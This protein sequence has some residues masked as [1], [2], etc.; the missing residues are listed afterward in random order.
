MDIFT[1]EYLIRNPALIG[2]PITCLAVLFAFKSWQINKTKLALDE[3]NLMNDF[4]SGVAAL[5]EIQEKIKRLTI[6][7][8]RE[9]SEEKKQ[10]DIELL[11]SIK[12]EIRTKEDKLR[13]LHIPLASVYN[14]VDFID[15]HISELSE[16]NEGKL[17]E[18]EEFYK[19]KR[20]L[21]AIYLSVALL[22]PSYI[23]RTVPDDYIKEKLYNDFF[24]EKWKAL[25]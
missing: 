2:V 4:Y 3:L 16:A 12:D 21:S 19:F 24:M 8:P 1:L 13:K 25:F 14:L 11:K 18:I 15:K 17:A 9:F 6:T 10:A 5:R 23:P 7:K 20:S 22:S